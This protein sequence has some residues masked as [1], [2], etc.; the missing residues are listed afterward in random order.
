MDEWML[1]ILSGTKLLSWDFSSW[2]VMRLYLILL[3]AND[4]NI[5]RDKYNKR[6]SVS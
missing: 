5:Y 4:N 2:S 3:L 1:I 6:K